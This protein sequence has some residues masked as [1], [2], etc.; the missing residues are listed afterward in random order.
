ME[1]G[2]DVEEV[3]EKGMV[4]L[5]IYVS[6]L[7]MEGSFSV[8]IGMLMYTLLVVI[9]DNDAKERGES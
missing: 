1:P 7:L 5:C 9:S 4:Q 6:W 2:F 3:V 8:L